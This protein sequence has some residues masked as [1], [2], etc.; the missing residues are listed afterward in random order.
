MKTELRIG[1]NIIGDD[2]PTYFI[3]DIAAN[4]DGSLRRA[5]E[6]IRQASDAGANGAK[7]QH[8]TAQTIVSDYGFKN[9]GQKIA[10]QAKWSKSVYDTYK[11]ASLNL[12]WTAELEET[13]KACGISYLTTPYNIE[14]VDYMRDYVVAYKIGSGDITWIDLIN[15]VASMD[16]PYMLATGASDLSD[17][18]RAVNSGLTLNE[19]LV[20]MQCNTNYTGNCDNFSYINLRVLTTYRSMFPKLIIGLSDH[21][22]GHST[23]LGAVA[24]GAKVIEKHF[25]DDTSREGPD[26]KFSMVPRSWKEMVDRTNELE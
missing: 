20:L 3:A 8:F 11:D 9:L 6:L 15:K 21:T 2:H 4:H 5:K 16:K 14:A 22:P 17:V 24:L 26:H 10:H 7:F 18:L 12:D 13:C 1:Q 19:K 25:T 23:V